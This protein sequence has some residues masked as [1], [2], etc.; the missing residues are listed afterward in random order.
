MEF[1]YPHVIENLSGEKLIFKQLVR[2]SQGDWLEVENEVQPNSGPPMHVHFQQD[3]SLTVVKGRMATQVLGEEPIFHEVGQSATFKAGVAHRFWNC[4]AEP[5]VCRGWIK[6]AH[7]LEYFLTE[8][9]KSTNENGGK[10]PGAFDSAYLLHRYRSEF[11][12]LEIPGFVK[13]VVFP[14]VLFLGR[15][16]GKHHKFQNAPIPFSG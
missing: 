3:E 4:G 2:D 7:N 5:L 13:K 11:D 6:P 12:M 14:V 8:I 15:L 16:T 1:Q 10:R 9:Y